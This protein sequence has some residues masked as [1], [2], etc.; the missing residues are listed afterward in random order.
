MGNSEG[1]PKEEAE[2]KWGRIL[3]K[4]LFLFLLDLEV[5]QARRYQNFLSILILKL[6]ALSKD[7]ER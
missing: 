7:D 2:V 5:K 1:R 6:N 3:D 4:N